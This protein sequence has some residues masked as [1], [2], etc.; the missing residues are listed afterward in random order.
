M[1]RFTLDDLIASYRS[2]VFPMSDGR[3]DEYLYLVDPPLRG[4][5]PLEQFHISS[6]LARTVKNT[7]FSVRIDTAFS[8]MIS[9]CAEQVDTRDGTW[10]SKPIQSLYEALFARGLA[11]SVEVWD[12]NKLLGG[13]YGVAIG[14]AFFGES[15]VSRARD[16]S[17]IALVHLVARLKVGGY[18]LLDCQ[19]QTEHLSQ[20]GTV[21][22]PRDDY[23]QLLSEALKLEGDF[24]DLSATATGSGVLQLTTQ[25]SYTG[26]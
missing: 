19:F 25:A 24:Y 8:Q 18:T 23:K 20:F 11:H 6:R 2:G 12:Q 4:I 22:I 9:L 3:E 5:L 15:M 21:E 7:P 17:K 1:P 14:G 13:L 26:C 16:V 10:I